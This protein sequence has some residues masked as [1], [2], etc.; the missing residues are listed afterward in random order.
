MASDFNPYFQ[1]TGR[2]VEL[3]VGVIVLAVALPLG[4]FG[5]RGAI[6]HLHGST[7]A[8]ADHVAAAVGIVAGLGGGYVGLRLLVG[9]HEDEAL[10]PAFFLFLAG[11]GA[12]AGGIWFAILSRGMHASDP[13]DSRFPYLFAVVGVGGILLAWRRWRGGKSGH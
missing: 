6:M 13:T 1:D 11:V 3:L 12:I 9:W 10:L 8:P 5:V 2:L 7:A 4:F